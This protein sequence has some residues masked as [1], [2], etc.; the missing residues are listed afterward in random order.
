MQKVD[1]IAMFAEEGYQ[2][3]P[4][5]VEVISAH[6]SPVELVGYI[7][8]TIDESVFVVEAEHIDLDGFKV[9]T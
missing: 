5:A 9:E 8:A 1:I 3:S 6:G 7:L 2:A 4:D